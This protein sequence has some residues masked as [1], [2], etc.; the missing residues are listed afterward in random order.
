MNTSFNDTTVSSHL[1]VYRDWI[2]SNGKWRLFWADDFDPYIGVEDQST[3]TGQPFFNTRR[4]A[5]AYGIKHHNEK[6]VTALFH[7]N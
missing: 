1:V 5:V 2:E 3:V 6:A 4:E 7:H